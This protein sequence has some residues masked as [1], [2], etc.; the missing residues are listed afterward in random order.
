MINKISNIFAN[1][2]YKYEGMPERDVTEYSLRFIFTNLITFLLIVLVGLLT[3]NLF[4]TLLAALSFSLFRMF[5]GGIHIKHPDLCILVSVTI[6]Y[7]VTNVPGYLNL[8]F[9]YFS[10]MSI[11]LTGIFAPSNIEDHSILNKNKHFIFKIISVLIIVAGFISKNDIVQFSFFVQSL[12]LIHLR[13]KGGEVN[14]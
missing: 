4:N 8:N 13:P 1:Y 6:I 3:N 10:V 7:L 11:V 14:E 2:L 12:T 5:S 9:V